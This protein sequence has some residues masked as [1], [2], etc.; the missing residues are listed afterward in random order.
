MRK[1]VSKSL[2]VPDDVIAAVARCEETS[3]LEIRERY[4]GGVCA[5]CG[6]AALPCAERHA[7][8]RSCV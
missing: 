6:Q 2:P 5:L 3:I 1:K 8:G 4:Q 7:K